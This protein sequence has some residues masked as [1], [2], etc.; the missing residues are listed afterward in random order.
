[1]TL[2]LKQVKLLWCLKFHVEQTTRELHAQGFTSPTIQALVT[3]GL[4]QTEFR[5]PYAY[6]TLTLFA[7]NV[8][9]KVEYLRLHFPVK[10]SEDFHAYTHRLINLIKSLKVD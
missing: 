9:S 2:T 10:D 6:T 1:M 7:K 4:V 5:D 3:A 8:I